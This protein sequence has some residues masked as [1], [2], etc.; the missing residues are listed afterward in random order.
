MF[1]EKHELAQEFPEHKDLIH[2]LKSSNAH[3]AKLQDEYHVVT[4]QIAR[5]EQEIETVSDVVAEDL[6]KKRLVLKDEIFAIINKA[7]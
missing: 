3:F 1:N 7:A 5:I 6:K 4:R 2:T